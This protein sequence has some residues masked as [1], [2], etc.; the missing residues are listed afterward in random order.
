MNVH[1]IGIA[2]KHPIEVRQEALKSD[3]P[4]EYP[5]PENKR[6]K[7]INEKWCA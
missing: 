3:I 6:I 5:I 7:N 4:V 1:R 2:A